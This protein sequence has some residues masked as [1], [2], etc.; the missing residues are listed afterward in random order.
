MKRLLLLVFVASSLLPRSA[1]GARTVAVLPL[2]LGAGSEVHAG[3]GTALAG[4]LVSD[5]SRVESLQLVERSRL[6]DLL[7]EIAIGEGDFLDPATAQKL[8]AGLGAELVVTGA[9]SVMGQT[10]LLD[11]RVVEVETAAIVQAV[12]AQGTVEDFVTVE[13][14]LVEALLD[15]LELALSSSVR[16][17]M[18]GTAPTED[19]GAFSSYSQGLDHQAKGRVDQAKAAFEA[20]LSIDPEF[21]EA[22]DAIATMRARVEEERAAVAQTASDRKTALRLAVLDRVPDER[23]RA[24]DFP[25][26]VQTVAEL[27]LRLMVLEELELHCQVYEEMWHYL[28]RV[29]WQ[30][31]QPPAQNGHDLFETTM[32]TAIEWELIEHPGRLRTIP[33]DNPTV[34]SMPGL[35]VSPPRFV[36]DL[37][38]ADLSEPKGEG[39]LA[40]LQRC[41]TPA[42][43]LDELD[44]IAERA[45]LA[46]VADLDES[47]HRPGV[48]LDDHLQ[49]AWAI[50]RARHFGADDEVHRRTVA[51]VDRHTDEIAR[52]WAVRRMENA[53]SMGD[54]WDMRQA[55]RLGLADEVLLGATR[56]VS[57]G[58]GPAID[59]DAPYCAAVAAQ[60]QSAAEWSWKR[61]QE[62]VEKEESQRRMDSFMPGLGSTLGSLLALGCI[63]GEP[64]IVNDVYEAYAWVGTAER[65][66]RED[67]AEDERCLESFEQLAQQ[68]DPAKLEPYEGNPQMQHHYAKYV[69]DWYYGALVIPRCVEP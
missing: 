1:L 25:D 9:F 33:F 45:R 43:Q 61:Y 67:H 7:A 34:A 65:R 68:T 53:A 60:A 21:V 57:E 46:S 12:D 29:D 35:F 16:R 54:L 47:E 39:L 31:S 49:T 6:D 32:L 56:A 13:K 52:A 20:A 18:L 40:S 50:L 24:A 64:G 38:A 26:D 30:V 23:T 8:G 37:A 42:E 28:D 14:D 22:R 51:V 41:F 11:A 36:L 62:M 63:A 15:G 4:M 58:E 5:L 3:L 69:L 17:K 10:F 19:F 27:G 2:E 66:I 55:Q 59:W 48:T 44:R